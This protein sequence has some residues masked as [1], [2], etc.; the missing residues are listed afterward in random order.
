MTSAT[1]PQGEREVAQVP[2]DAAILDGFPADYSD[3]FSVATVPGTAAAEWARRCLSGADVA[4]GAF[5]NVVWHGVLGFDL[6]STDAPGTLVGW[7][8]STD[9]P[10]HFI[11]DADGRLMRWR[12]VFDV[13]TTT[14]T[15]TTMLAFH[16]PAAARIWAVAGHVHRALAPKLLGKARSSLHRRHG[17]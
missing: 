7:R 16:R 11:L 8:I 10:K 2:T 9:Q 13:S 3:T 1:G 14:V 4:N 6:A 12:M 15:W 17:G 5:R